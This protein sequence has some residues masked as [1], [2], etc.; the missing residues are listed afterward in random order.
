MPK[1]NFHPVVTHTT[2]TDVPVLDLVHIAASDQGLIAIAFN[3]SVEVFLRQ[4]ATV[5]QHILPAGGKEILNTRNQFREYLGGSRR[6]FSL[7]LDITHLTV[8]QRVVLE[9][10]VQV[11]YGE[12]CSYAQIASR[13]GCPQSARAVGRAIARNPLPIIIPCHRI[14]NSNGSL[15]GYS[16]PGGLHTKRSLLDLENA[17]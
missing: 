8:F 1:H 6:Q 11:P 13:M 7:P 12:T 15:G 5:H 3:V 16:C 17:C 10:V 2:L 14:I 9:A 4:L